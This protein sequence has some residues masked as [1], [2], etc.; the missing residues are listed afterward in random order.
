VEMIPKRESLAER[1]EHLI[2]IS[3]IKE[4]TLWGFYSSCLESAKTDP[5][6]DFTQDNKETFNRLKLR[7]IESR[8]KKLED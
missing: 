7:S 3:N 1:F 6:V 2:Y 8:M 5:F 4:D